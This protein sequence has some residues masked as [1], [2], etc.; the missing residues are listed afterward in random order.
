MRRGGMLLAR[1]PSVNGFFNPTPRLLK[2]MGGDLIIISPGDIILDRDDQHRSLRPAGP[3]RFL[4]QQLG[5]LDR[6]PVTHTDCVLH[7]R[8]V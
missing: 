8:S 7:E 2:R 1:L 5:H 4:F 3:D 6:Q